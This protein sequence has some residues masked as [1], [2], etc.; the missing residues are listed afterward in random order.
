MNTQLYNTLCHAYDYCVREEKYKKECERL[1]HRWATGGLRLSEFPPIFI[2]KREF[3]W[4]RTLIGFLV[5]WPVGVFF[6]AQ[7]LVPTLF[8]YIRYLIQKATFNYKEYEE[9]KKKGADEARAELTKTER[10]WQKFK[11][12][13]LQYINQVPKDFRTA[14]DISS[15]KFYV[16]RGKAYTM[17][18]AISLWCDC[19]FKI[20]EERERAEKEREREQEIERRHKETQAK[21]GAI[22]EN[23]RKILREQQ[24][25]RDWRDVHFRSY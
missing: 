2:L 14:E 9:K 22:K 21:L 7:F 19:R 23:Q 17:D 24:E 18:Q 25:A 20:Y 3:K 15:I 10:E 8:S 6:L 5:F 16:E 12:E 4:K 1:N 13:N 11:A